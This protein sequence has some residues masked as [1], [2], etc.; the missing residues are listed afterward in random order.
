MHYDYIIVG[1]GSAG[2]I[3]AARLTENPTIKVLLVE[4][5]G[6]PAGSSSPCPQHS[7]LPT[8]VK[9]LAGGISQAP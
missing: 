8:R 3:V 9:S 4:A 1:A 6:P 7:R 5:G 2:C